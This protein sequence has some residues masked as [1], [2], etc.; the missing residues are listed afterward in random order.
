[1]PDDDDDATLF[2]SGVRDLS[3]KLVVVKGEDRISKQAQ[4]NATMLFNMLLR[5]TLCAKRVI[6]EHHMTMESFDW[7]LGEIETRF[8]QALVRV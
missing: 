4:L 2:L 1:M 8:N 7:L 5:S 6:D 3:K